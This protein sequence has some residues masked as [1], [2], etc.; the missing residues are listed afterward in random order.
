MRSFEAIHDAIWPN[1][2][3]IAEVLVLSVPMI[4]KWMQP[5]IDPEDSGAKNPLDRL[6]MIIKTAIENGRS[7]EKAFAPLRYLAGK[8]NI[9]LLPIPKPDPNL[10]DVTEGF[11]KTVKEFSDFSAKYAEAIKDKRI[12]APAAEAIDTEVWHLIQQAVIFNAEVKRV[13]R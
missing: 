4:Y 3:E 2:Q 10:G 7:D 5:K 12:S 1:V 8:F 11:A 13:V 6:E 9:A